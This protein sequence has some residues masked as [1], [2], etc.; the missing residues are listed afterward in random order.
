MTNIT[1]EKNVT[2]YQ[3]IKLYFLHIQWVI[4]F[5]SLQHQHL[6]DNKVILWTT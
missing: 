6:M 5:S 1:N 3:Q 4:N 2:T